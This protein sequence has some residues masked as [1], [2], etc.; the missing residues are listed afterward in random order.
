[1][2]ESDRSLL[3]FH[4]VHAIVTNASADHFPKEEAVA[5]FEKFCSQLNARGISERQSIVVSGIAVAQPYRF[6]SIHVDSTRFES[7]LLEWSSSFEWEGVVYEVPMPGEHNALNAW[8]AIRRALALGCEGE[9][10]ALALKNFKGVERRLEH[11]GTRKDGVMVID[12]YAHNTEKL[13]AVWKTLAERSTR[14]LALW[15]PHGYG[16]LRAMLEPLTAMFAETMRPDDQLYVLPVYDA[17]GTA[18][19]SI[20]SDALV[21]A[22]S[23]KGAHAIAVPSH[24]AALNALSAEIAPGDIV[25]TLGARDPELPRTARKLAE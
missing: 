19:R 10:I 8:M 15:R 11:I 25:A 22:V 21:S 4:P 9:K 12:D 1:V 13:R 17:G 14:V 24:E 6:E 5:L 23:R 16:P 2:D 7:T 18:D 3:A 20:T